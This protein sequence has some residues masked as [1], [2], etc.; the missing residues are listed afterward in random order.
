MKK[1]PSRTVQICVKVDEVI[2]GR[3]DRLVPA[4]SVQ[5]GV[6]AGRADVMRAALLQGLAEMEKGDAKGR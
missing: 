3:L 5:L 6:A 2:V 4:M 1:K